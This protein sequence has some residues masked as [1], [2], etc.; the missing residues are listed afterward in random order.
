[1]ASQ[2]FGS[3]FLRESSKK[4]FVDFGHLLSSLASFVLW[5]IRAFIRLRRHAS[6]G[7][8]RGSR[9]VPGVSR[10]APSGNSG[11]RPLGCFCRSLRGCEKGGGHLLCPGVRRAPGHKT[12]ELMR[13]ANQG[14]IPISGP[15]TK[16]AQDCMNG[17]I[18]C[19]NGRRLCTNGTNGRRLCTNFHLG[20][21]RGFLNS[22]LCICNS[23]LCLCNSGL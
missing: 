9:S 14:R 21:T 20:V 16:L 15:S 12:Q 11:V 5:R 17:R 2:Y 23:G 19:T 22:G 7:V 8:P 13:P 4:F 6:E 18:L 10:G 1:M 3:Q